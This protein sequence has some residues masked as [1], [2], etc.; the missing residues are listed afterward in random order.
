MVHAVRVCSPLTFCVL[1][2][3]GREAFNDVVALLALLTTI[4]VSPAV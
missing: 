3:T 4:E 2:T 1:H